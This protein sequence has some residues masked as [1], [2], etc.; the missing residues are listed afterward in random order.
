MVHGGSDPLIELIEITRDY[1][2]GRHVVHALSDVTLQVVAGEFV[3][4]TGPSGAGKSTLLHLLGGLDR[5]TAGVYR[6]G[7]TNVGS[8]DGNGMA[9]FRRDAV[10]L[11]LQAESL[12]WSATAVENVALP[13]SYRGLRRK[14]REENA[15]ELLVSLGLGDR[16]DHFPHELSGG[17]RQRVAIAR[18]LINGSEVILADEPTDGLDSASSA[19]VLKQLGDLATAGRT[20]LVATHDVGLAP[21]ADSHLEINDGRVVRYETA[22]EPP[23]WL[24]SP[25]RSTEL[26]LASKGRRFHIEDLREGFKTIHRSVWRNSRVAAILTGTAIAV[27]VLSLITVMSVVAGASREGLVAVTQLGLDRIGVSPSGHYGAN[28]VRLSIG[29]VK[30]IRD[31]VANLRH[32]TGSVSGKKHVQFGA[33]SLEVF[34]EASDENTPED[35]DWSLDQGAFFSPNQDSLREPVAVLG[36]GVGA[37]LFSGE[38]NPI[39]EHVL[40]DRQPFEVVGVLSRHSARHGLLRD[41]FD[42]TV[43]VPFDAGA[44]LLFGA[45]NITI[46]AFTDDP[47]GIEAAARAIRDL[48]VRRHGREGFIVSTRAGTIDEWPA[49]RRHFE[50]VVAAVSI[51]MAFLGGF[52]VSAL[53]LLSARRR[54]REIGIRM[55]VGATRG[56][57]ARQF[58]L[59]A[60]ILATV[61]GAT[62]IVGGLGVAYLLTLAHV[63]IEVASWHILTA[64]GGTATVGALFGTIPARK[65]ARVDPI[66]ALTRD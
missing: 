28:P 60:A 14:E 27:A 45:D 17:E 32:V 35:L 39:G 34:V 66:A 23:R 25:S 44:N 1:R 18:A 64:F 54:T 48:L 56:D 19:R 9:A 31:G 65:A 20:V 61:G 11:V 43:Y 37:A 10:G 52:G 50:G 29:D 2:D 24:A 3:C 40:I 16:L 53:L 33:R 26:V 21:C 58:V 46:A 22:R 38:G 5:P 55:A 41:L 30:A 36:A 7:Q 8:L 13:A 49:V 12:I 47:N 63:P 15:C 57:I 62:G 59:E 6:F 42:A 51:G 4:V